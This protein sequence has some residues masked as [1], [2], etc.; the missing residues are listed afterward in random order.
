MKEKLIGFLVILIFQRH[1][2]FSFYKLNK[3]INPGISSNTFA[4]FEEPLVQDASGSLE[5]FVMVRL[6]IFCI[7]G[8]VVKKKRIHK[9]MKFKN[10]EMCIYLFSSKDIYLFLFYPIAPFSIP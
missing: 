1:Q 5:L 4:S 6:K 2:K 9:N 8:R 10:T 3:I 7:I